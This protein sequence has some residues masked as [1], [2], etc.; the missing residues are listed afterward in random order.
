MN[1]IYFCLALFITASFASMA[2]NV[3]IGIAAPTQKLHVA[4]GASPNTATIR[5]S[6][7]SGTSA[8]AAGTAPFR[9]VLVD[10]NGVMYRGGTAGSGN[11]DAWYTLGN[12]G[13]TD[14]THFLGTTDA[15][16]IDFRTNNIIRMTMSSGGYLGLGTVTPANYVH[17]TKTGPTG[18]G[19]WQTYWEN[20][21][22]GD[23][24]SQ[25][26]NTN[27]GNGSRVAMGIT[28]YN[29]NAFE[30]VGVFGLAL[31]TATVPGAGVIGTVGVK[32]FN[33]S[34]EGNGVEG[35]FTGG[36][37][38]TAPGW[39]VFAEGWGG[40]LTAWQNVSDAR[41]KKDVQTIP[42]ALQKVLQLR[43]VEYYFDKTNYPMLNV[44]E[45]HKQIGFVAQ[46]VEAIMPELIREANIRASGGQPQSA[47]TKTAASSYLL[48][49]FSYSSIVP[50][51]VEALK[52]QQQIINDLK[53]RVEKLEHP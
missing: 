48:K 9:V 33:N 45:T 10:N 6:G 31:N 41:I 52:E 49:T 3:G 19:I 16:R 17:F 21:G 24:V 15:R 47:D 39:A 11:T 20:T 7:L 37:L 40:G 28:N 8:L 13:L 2:Q 36:T 27:V 35:G 50:V 44:C 12:A 34:D 32:G 38:P 26:Y 46:E 43:G 25:W 5:V 29:T 18:A 51:L 1:K 14:G 30:A 4:D 53:T 22:T 23:A 42:N